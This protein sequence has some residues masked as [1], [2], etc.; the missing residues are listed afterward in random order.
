MMARIKSLAVTM[1]HPSLHIVSLHDIKQIAKE[2]IKALSVLGSGGL[3]VIQKGPSE[4]CYHVGISGLAD[5][6]MKDR[7][8]T[9]AMLGHVKD[10]ANL[11]TYCTAEESGKCAVSS[12]VGGM[13]KSTYKGGGGHFQD[14]T[15]ASRCE[16]CGPTH[17]VPGRTERIL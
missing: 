5:P 11:V 2:I 17:Q 12:T 3:Q 8:L 7:A 6:D 1:L 14:Y 13:R 16:F 4:T 10:L 15:P 9:T